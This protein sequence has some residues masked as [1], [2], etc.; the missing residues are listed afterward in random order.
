MI[1]K[2]LTLAALAAAA[3]L[4]ACD[5]D[6]V[7]GPGFVCDVTNPVR[8]IIVSPGSSQILVHSPA[9]DGDTVV[10][11]AIATNR[12]GAGRSDVPI[13]FRSSDN[14]VAT[15]D[16]DGVV[17]AIRP[18]TVRITASACGESASVDV[19]I[20][21]SVLSV[22]VVPGAD[23]VVAGDSTSFTARAFAPGGAQIANAKFTFSS[24]SAGVSLTQT[25]DTTV[26]AVT[27]LQP[28]TFVVSAL[29]EGVT[30]SASLIALP[31]V[32]MAGSIVANG[33]DAGDAIT[34]GIISKGQAFCWGLNNH[35]QLGA[36]TDSVCFGGTSPGEVTEDTVVTSALP[37]RLLPLRVGPDLEFASISAGDSTSC[38][39]VVSGRAYCWGNGTFGTVGN[40]KVG[41]P[42]QPEV[43]TF[44][45]TFSSLSVGGQHACGLATGGFAYCWG[46]D[47]FGQLG[48]LREINSTTPI[49]VILNE[50]HAVFASISA[51]W[52]H[53]C[54]LTPS[55][56]AYCWGSNERGQLGAG[57]TGGYSTFPLAVAGGLSF[58]SLS[59]GGDHTCG[60]T[61]SG[62]AFCWGSNLEGQL[63]NGGVGGVSGVP[64]AAAAGLSFTRISASTGT[65]SLVTP[66][67]PAWKPEGLGHS[68]GLTTG[69]AIYCWGDNGILQLGRGP[70]S[71]GGFP[72]GAPQLV[73]GGELPGGV[74]FVSVTTGSRHSCG[75]GS[76][77]AAY[78][79]G[80]N[81]YGALGNTYQAHFRGLPQRVATP[82]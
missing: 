73:T 45:Q 11:S 39:I 55:G 66:L 33:I 76:D 16:S 50:A 8:D 22:T 57:G 59:A 15:V 27:S 12:F 24:S 72:S 81:V 65:R 26:T 67:G 80:S 1:R 79:W 75:V 7:T 69:G 54:A 43:V 38:G 74:T 51:G 46:D 37:C 70:F 14:T 23:T 41:T 63:G 48:D 47:T 28:G 60:L 3:S 49:P 35:G 62:A 53:T 25:S 64:V 4:A 30:G 78:C 71:G 6:D 31:R 20:V 13:T 52:R 58:A 2:A 21:S 44:A 61:T 77:G 17:R 29:T 9:L 32:F 40:G 34:C 56:A 82:R 5:D 36:V 10:V 68:C 42:T 19:S 18:G